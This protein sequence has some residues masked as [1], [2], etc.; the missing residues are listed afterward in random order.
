MFDQ[1]NQVLNNNLITVLFRS[2]APTPLLSKYVSV[3]IDSILATDNPILFG[4]CGLLVAKTPTFF[5]CALGGQT[6]DER[7]VSFF[8]SDF[9]SFALYQLDLNEIEK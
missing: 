2:F 8:P 6:L 9:I 7:N 1:L 5:P 3:V 4:R